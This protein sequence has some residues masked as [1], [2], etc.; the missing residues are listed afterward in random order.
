MNYTVDLLSLQTPEHLRSGQEHQNRFDCGD[1]EINIF[2]TFQSSLKVKIVYPGLTISSMIRGKKT[3]YTN[4]GERFEF[5]PGTS[6][7]LPEGETIYADF[8][9]ADAKNPVQCATILIPQATLEKQL[10]YLNKN[11][12][13]NGPWELDFRHFHFNNNVGLVR[14][15][16]ELLQ[17][18]NQEKNNYPLFDLILKSL[19]VRLITAQQ[20]HI[21]VHELGKY[22]QQFLDLKN[23]IKEHLHLAISTDQLMDIANCSKSTL[24]RIFDAYTGKTPGQYIMQERLAKACNMLLQGELSI[25]EVGFRSGFNSSSYFVKQFRAMYQCTPGEYVKK[26]C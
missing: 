11:Y 25:S 15:F 24:F 6:L 1:F 2:E 26:F 23:Y 14:S 19:F 10:K 17:A 18:I 4:A 7:V 5:Q 13:K 22:Q 20:E 12:K 8:P 9:E 16:N 3:V 21:Q